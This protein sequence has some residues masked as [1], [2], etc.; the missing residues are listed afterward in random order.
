MGIKK[1]IRVKKE[2]HELVWDEGQTESLQ[3]LN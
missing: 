1:D 2:Q 3:S